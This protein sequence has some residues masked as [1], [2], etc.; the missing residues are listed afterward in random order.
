MKLIYISKA[1]YL[2]VHYAIKRT[3]LWRWIGEMVIIFSGVI[4]GNAMLPDA[5]LRGVLIIASVVFLF[6]GCLLMN[7]NK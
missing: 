6:V 1:A 4:F 3:K 7:Q 5:K 2:Y